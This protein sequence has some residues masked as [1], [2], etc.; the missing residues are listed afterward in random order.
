MRIVHLA[1]E[2]A[3][4][5]KVGGLG[6]VVGALPQA[7]N[8]LGDHQICVIVPYYGAIVSAAFGM[9]PFA[10]FSIQWN[11]AETQVEVAHVHH[12]G[13]DIY[14][15]RGWPFFSADEVFIY[16][17]DDGVNLGRY[18]FFCAAA[19]E[20]IRILSDQE[21]WVP[22]IV[23]LHDWHAALAAMLL[24]TKYRNDA[25]LRHTASV[26]SIHNMM[27]Q[28]W[29]VGWHLDRAGLPPIAHPLLR[30]MGKTENS[31]AIGLA[32]STM[33]STVSPT[34]AREITTSEGG[35]DLE[36]LLE[37][38]VAH[39]LGILNG[40]DSARW[41][42]S[43]SAVLLSSFDE[44]SL[45]ERSANK[46]ALQA[47]VGLPVSSSV[48]LLSSVT[49]L[50]GQKGLDIMIPVLRQLMT[51]TQVQVVILGSG[52][53]EFETALL[54][55]ARDFPERI[56]VKLGFDEPLSERIYAGADLF[57][58]PSQF[59]PCGIG[60]MIA[61]RYGCLPVVRQVGGLAD[62]VDQTT[63]FLFKPYEIEALRAT[64]E[65]ALRIYASDQLR[66]R[67]MQVAA[68]QRDFSWEASARR[69][70]DLYS[71]AID[72]KRQYG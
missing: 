5:V 62:T 4:F 44:H 71:L 43:T 14:F 67:R 66:W 53:V 72:S 2:C 68:M 10:A 3:P 60:Q 50:V 16:H 46:D 26:L 34:Y 31:L 39:M 32:Y 38:R 64:V 45:E 63:G 12:E 35:Y 23:H 33:L 58:M 40:L 36:G 30:A 15:L 70:I 9:E 13:V 24:A 8:R 17:G 28:G 19:L 18:L 1:A 37:A 54:D 41:N 52:M 55:L 51:T 22:D 6:D 20:F 49:R 69:Y 21:G 48:P 11:G 7:L 27:Y 57:L 25:H 29:G 42:P 59:E 65:D 61:L 56:A 47:E